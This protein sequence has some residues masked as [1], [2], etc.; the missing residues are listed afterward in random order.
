M[1]K[2]T[3]FTRDFTWMI[4][5]QI[6]SLFGNSIVRF[7]LSLKVLEMTGSAASFAMITGASMV[8]TILLSPLGGLI[9]DRMSKRDIMAGL[10][11][12]TCG[13]CIAF[14]VILDVHLDVMGIAAMMMVLAVIQSFYQPAVQASIP[15]L[16]ADEHLMQANGIA[17]QVNALANL[18]GPML[19]GLFYGFFGLIPILM[20]S[21]A[22]FFCSAVM[23]MFLHIPFVKKKENDD[24]AIRDLQ[25][26]VRFVIREHP[27]I[28]RFL[29]ILAMLNLFLSALLLIGLPYIIRIDLGLSAQ[30][31]GVAEGIMGLGSIAAG[32]V[33]GMVSRRIPFHRSYRLLMGGVV[34]L[35]PIAVVL[36]WDIHALTAYAILLLSVFLAMLFIGVFNIFIQTYLQQI[37]PADMLGKVSA[38]VATIVMC[39]LPVGQ[40]LYGYLFDAVDHIYWILLFG[41]AAGI[42]LTVLTKRTLYQLHKA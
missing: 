19:G 33:V 38:F 1:K 40:A 12:L 41:I 37:T 16:A 27:A 26:A 32:L 35:L 11:F 21:A 23:E 34:V 10:D 42:V 7:A 22:A 15:L 20:I 5:G 8:L 2:Y 6:I 29:M 13:I 28:F 17:M 39:S 9:A 25:R 18:I 36:F 24:G 30:L 14:H 31:Y 3:V 4:I